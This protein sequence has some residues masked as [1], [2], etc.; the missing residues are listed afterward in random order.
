MLV[1]LL[2]LSKS[3]F[4]ENDDHH[5][6]TD[7]DLSRDPFELAS[8]LH[9]QENEKRE[10]YERMV[11]FHDVVFKLF[12]KSRSKDDC[13]TKYQILDQAKFVLS[14]TNV[15]SWNKDALLLG[16]IKLGDQAATLADEII[17]GEPF[18]DEEFRLFCTE[19]GKIR[20]KESMRVLN[21]YAAIFAAKCEN[22][23]LDFALISGKNGIFLQQ[24]FISRRGC[25]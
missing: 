4:S 7:S 6:Q 2:F 12:Q 15:S 23:N 9:S 10:N 20:T 25:L 16:K 18:C 22:D 19:V 8:P 1:L 5:A 14:N 3:I 13:V 11:Y 17:T 24:T 21:D